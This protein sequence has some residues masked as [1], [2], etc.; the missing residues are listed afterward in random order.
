MQIVLGGCRFDMEHFQRAIQITN[1]VSD[2]TENG[3]FVPHTKL[4]VAASRF[5]MKRTRP[6]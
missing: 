1:P 3:A 5:R 6:E 4:P 2:R